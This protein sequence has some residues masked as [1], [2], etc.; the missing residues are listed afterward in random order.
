MSLNF[1]IKMTGSVSTFYTIVW[2][3]MNTKIFY[4]TKKDLMNFNISNISIVIEM[5]NVI[6]SI[7]Y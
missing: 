3:F 5:L 1:K 7:H 2:N 4:F 6:M